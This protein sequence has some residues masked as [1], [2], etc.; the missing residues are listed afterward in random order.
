MLRPWG[1]A[2]KMLRDRIAIR[3]ISKN[4][5]FRGFSALSA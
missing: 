3:E 1:D 5:A 2:G 4:T